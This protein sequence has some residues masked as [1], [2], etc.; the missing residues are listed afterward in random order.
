LNRAFTGVRVAWCPDLGC[1]P[2]DQRVRDVLNA[3]RRTFET[4]G[5]IVEDAH[6]DLKDA[7]EVFLTLR[8]F[9]T[10][11]SLGALLPKHRA[12]MKPEAIA[13]I[14]AGAGLTTAQ[15]SRALVRQ[16]QLRETLS[17]FH[18]QYEFLLTAVNQVPPFDASIHWPTEIDGVP[19]EH[20]IA[21]MKSAYWISATGQPAISVPAGFTA[22]AL[23][24]GL[25][26]VGR[27]RGDF[28]VLQLAHAFEQASG[29]GLRRPS[30]PQP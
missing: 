23:P 13:E 12:Q 17:K 22:D 7:D 1:L 16:D 5:C 26:I 20:Y 29:A 27:H 4:L 3:Q 6:P 2:L 28:G 24:V 15:L 21:W 8:A 9:R 10:W 25:Q 11:T 18:E 30:L 19:M 14:E